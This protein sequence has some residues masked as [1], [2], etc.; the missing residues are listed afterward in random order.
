ML[1]KAI[2]EDEYKEWEEILKVSNIESAEEDL[3][4]TV[5]FFNNTLKPGE[6]PRSLISYS[7]RGYT[8]VIPILRSIF[9]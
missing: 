1:A 7:V 3:Q 2:I 5:S 9:Y 8:K 6:T 4:N